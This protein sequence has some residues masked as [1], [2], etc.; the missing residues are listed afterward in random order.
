MNGVQ[1]IVGLHRAALIGKILGMAAQKLL[2]LLAAVPRPDVPHRPCSAEAA[3]KM[4]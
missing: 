3:A 4:R 2:H 1:D